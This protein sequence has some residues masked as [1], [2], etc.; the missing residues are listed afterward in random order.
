M[1]REKQRK[2]GIHTKSK[3][4]REKHTDREIERKKWIIKKL[5]IL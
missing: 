3:R 5:Q 4:E 1:E 2:S